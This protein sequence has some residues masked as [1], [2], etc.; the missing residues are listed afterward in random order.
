MGETVFYLYDPLHVDASEDEQEQIADQSGT[1]SRVE[2]DPADGGYVDDQIAGCCRGSRDP[3]T[4]GFHVSHI[5]S[6]QESGHTEEEH[7]HKEDGNLVVCRRVISSDQEFEQ[8][9]RCRDQ[10]PE[11]PRHKVEHGPEHGGIVL[12]GVAVPGDYRSILLP[13]HGKGVL[14]NI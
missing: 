9:R 6:S 2:T 8:N 1:G 14:S 11:E 4:L 7:A 5:N 13:R 10:E 3:D 12:A